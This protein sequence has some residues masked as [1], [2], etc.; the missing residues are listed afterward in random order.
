RRRRRCAAGSWPWRSAARCWWPPW[1]RSRGR[2]TAEAPRRGARQR[3][4]VV[5]V[6]VEERAAPALVE[7]G[8]AL[9]EHVERDARRGARLVGPAAGGERVGVDQPDEDLGLVDAELLEELERAPRF[10]EGL[11]GPTLLQQRLGERRAG[12]AAHRRHVG[13]QLERA[14]RV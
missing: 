2:S 6:A 4:G 7:A 5:G 11:F 14:A 1:P 10:G 9:V 13:H 12:R 8:G 3:R